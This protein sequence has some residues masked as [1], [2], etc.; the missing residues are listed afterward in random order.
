[1]QTLRGRTCVFAG[2]TV[3]DGP[4]TVRALC[5]GGMNVAVFTHQ[6]KAAKRLKH[7]LEKS[8]F[9]G[10]F[11]IC[12]D[13]R[14]RRKPREELFSEVRDA[15]GSVDVIISNTGGDGKQDSLETLEPSALLHSMDHLVCGSFELLKAGLPYLKESRAPRVIFMT[16]AEGCMGGTYESFS[17]AVAK[18]AVRALTLNAAARLAGYGITVNCISKGSIPRMEGIPENGM[19]LSVRLPVI[20]MG[21]LGT[22]SDLAGAVC[23]LASEESSYITGQVLELSGGLNLGR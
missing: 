1:M 6:P 20:P 12:A 2:A 21:R 11:L 14:R 7:E 19:D 15:F 17:N 18:G 10:G 23:F 13:G 16:T 5:K 22:Q 9:E 4:E 8:G 3:G